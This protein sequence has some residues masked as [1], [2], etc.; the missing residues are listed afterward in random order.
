[1]DTQS[2]NTE[3]QA[4]PVA[5]KPSIDPL[6]R[7]FVPIEHKTSRGTIVFRTTDNRMYAR[8]VDGSIRRAIPKQRGKSA[9][10]ADKQQRRQAA[11]D[12]GRDP[13]TDKHPETG[14]PGSTPSKPGDGT[15]QPAP[16]GVGTGTHGDPS[17]EPAAQPKGDHNDDQ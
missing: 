13:R 14:I 6:R 16:G 10:R 5:K 3:G 1:M 12:A 17:K 4:P 2:R 7:V 15:T 9:R 11:M 8:V